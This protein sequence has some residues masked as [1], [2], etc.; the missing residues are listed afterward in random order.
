MKKE[1]KWKIAQENE[2]NFWKDTKPM[3]NKEGVERWWG[4]HWE[5]ARLEITEKDKII[6]IGGG[7]F[8]MISESP[9]KTSRM[10]VIEPLAEKY[11]E[12]GYELDPN[13]D[14]ISEP[15]EKIEFSGNDKFTILIS[16][17]CL[18]HVSDVSKA[19]EKISISLETNGK[20]FIC[21]D[22]KRFPFRIISKIVSDFMRNNPKYSRI[23]PLNKI[24]AVIND[25]CH[26]SPLSFKFLR[27]LFESNRLNIE[28]TEYWR[29]N[30][31]SIRTK[32][33]QK[34]LL[35]WLKKK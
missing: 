2:L 4:I 8:P 5:K 20:A 17:N 15:I 34:Q 24:I 7:P 23:F 19:I 32:L 12:L 11:K 3:R 18:D 26:P 9:I 35:V 31:V 21:V 6:E 25:P 10:V 30:K 22:V 14:W 28:K 27:K 33:Q 1:H 16:V 29:P 13:L